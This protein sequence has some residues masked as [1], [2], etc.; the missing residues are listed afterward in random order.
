MDITHYLDDVGELG[1]MPGPA[2]KLASFLVLLIDATTQ[3]FPVD[4]HDT[5]I[6]CRENAC[7]GSIRTSLLTVIEEISWHCPE[8]GHHG[9]IRKWQDTKWDQTKSES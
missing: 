7:T 1:E 9:V 5:H 4:D 6:R 2:R 3:A 8:C